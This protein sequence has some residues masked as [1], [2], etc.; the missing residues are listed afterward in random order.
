LAFFHQFVD[1]RDLRFVIAWT[2]TAAIVLASVST[3]A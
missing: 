1:L 3:A 2:P